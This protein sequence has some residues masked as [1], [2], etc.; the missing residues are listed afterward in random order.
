[1]VHDLPLYKKM[2]EQNRLL[3]KAGEVPE[4]LHTYQKTYLNVQEILQHQFDDI[5][6]RREF[7]E[8]YSIGAE[9][10]KQVRVE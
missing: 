3:G 1:M 8:A 6:E 7:R 2:L 9:V 5:M 4:W 10:H